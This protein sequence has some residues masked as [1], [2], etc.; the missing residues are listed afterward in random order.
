MFCS[1]IIL[2][3]YHKTPPITHS[4]SIGIALCQPIVTRDKP[5][6]L[7]TAERLIRQAVAEHRPRIVTLPEFFNAPYLNGEM[8]THAELIPA[9]P[10]CQL[11]GGLAAELGV[12][13]VGGSIPELALDG[14]LFN[15]TTVWSPSGQLL[16]TYRK[17]H[18]ADA[19]FSE[20]L[21]C[22]ESLVITA[23]DRLGMFEVDG[24]RFGL[25]I[26]YDTFFPETAALYRRHGVD[27][28]LYNSA[29]PPEAGMWWE[30]VLRARA[31]DNQ[32]FGRVCGAV[33][34]VHVLWRVAG[35]GRLGPGDWASGQ[36]RGRDFHGDWLVLWRRV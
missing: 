16:T 27:M 6:N 25:G 36:G 35:G 1:N 34:S 22:T 14:R 12:C 7:A 30:L 9:G 23:G 21:T 28:I 19:K 5:T 15:T 2:H 17:L 20:Q 32:L 4:E 3:F 11:L 26:C 31:L 13:L 24:R 33:R 18:M 8:R 10:T 29:F